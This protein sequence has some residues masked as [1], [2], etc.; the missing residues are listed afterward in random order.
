MG[1]V[2]SPLEKL[3]LAKNK[4][5]KCPECNKY[6]LTIENFSSAECV[7]GCTISDNDLIMD[8]LNSNDCRAD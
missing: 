1:S 3:L 8:I 2:K 4:K 5:Y 7:E 6:T